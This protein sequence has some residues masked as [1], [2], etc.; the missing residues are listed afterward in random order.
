MVNSTV[1]KARISRVIAATRFPFVGQTDWDESRTTIANDPVYPEWSFDTPDGSLAP[2]VVVLN[3]DGSVR[4]C[5]EVELDTEYNDSHVKKWR[6]MSSLTG[7]GEKFKKF[8]LYVPEGSEEQALR[9][10]EESGIEYAGL[11]TWG[12]D[13]W[14]LVLK[15]FKTPDMAKDHR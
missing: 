15:P 7:M 10:L 14:N 13:N 3:A 8:F 2:S 11:R 9:L 6:T 1:L 4:E 5:G 12:L